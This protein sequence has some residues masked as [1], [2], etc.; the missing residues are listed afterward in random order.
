MAR[1]LAE[2]HLPSSVT[3]GSSVRTK[4]IEREIRRRLPWSTRKSLTVETG[5]VVLHVPDAEAAE[6]DALSAIVGDM[7]PEFATLPILPSEAEDILSIS[8]RERHKW[9]DD[10]RLPECRH[11]DGQAAWPCEGHGVPHVF[12]PGFIE[13]VLDSGLSE[14]WREED[15]ATA[16]ENRRRAAAKAALTRAGKRPAKSRK[17]A[18][19]DEVAT[20]LEGW[21][22]FKLP[23]CFARGDLNYP[24]KSG[25]EFTIARIMVGKI[26]FA[27][28]AQRDL[29]SMR[30]TQA[31]APTTQV[32]KTNRVDENF[33]AADSLGNAGNFLRARTHRNIPS[34]MKL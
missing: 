6:F 20:G 7:L 12:T 16:A 15:I 19:T 27:G 10:G 31:A 32:E 5:K 1:P 13:H 9:L 22:E 33:S 26:R 21:D 2:W 8:S 14:I 25:I 3:L 4:G 30:A 29:K 34:S 24:C 23:V 18:Q 11:Q 17:V 28:Q